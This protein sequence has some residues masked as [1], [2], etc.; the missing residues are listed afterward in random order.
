METKREIWEDALRCIIPIF[1]DRGVELD[2]K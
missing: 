2:T 1:Q